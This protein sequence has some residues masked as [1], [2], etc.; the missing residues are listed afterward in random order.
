MK[1]PLVADT[2]RTISTDYGVLKED[3]GIAYRWE[4]QYPVAISYTIYL[5]DNCKLYFIVQISDFVD[6]ERDRPLLILLLKEMSLPCSTDETKIQV[7]V[8]NKW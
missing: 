5:Y 3:E 4:W 2:R 8:E 6:R 7:R 1:I